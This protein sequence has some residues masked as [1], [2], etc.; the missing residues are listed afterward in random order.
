VSADLALTI[1]LIER[2][3]RH[4]GLDWC[5]ESALLEELQITGLAAGLI[6]KA[7]KG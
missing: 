2:G 1:W 3:P 7:D 6:A 5:L 4:F